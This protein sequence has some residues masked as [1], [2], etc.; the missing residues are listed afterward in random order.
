M[1]FWS[2]KNGTNKK[3]ESIAAK[4]ADVTMKHHFKSDNSCYHV[5]VYD[6]TAG[7]FIKGVTHQGYSDASMWARGQAWAIY[8][9]TLCYRETRDN[10]YLDFA[11]KIADSYLARLPDDYVPYW[12]FDDPAIP[13]SP[14]D[15]SAAAITASALL[16]LSGFVQGKKSTTYRNSAISMLKNLYHNYRSETGKHSFLLHSTGHKPGGYEIDASIIYADY[17]F[18]EALL[19]VLQSD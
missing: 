4:H 8:G 6:T 19:K 10:R 2:A 17:Y 16:D 14:R 15:A 11:Q 3:L 1:L 9:Y 5:A 18:A 7:N 13:D 12:D